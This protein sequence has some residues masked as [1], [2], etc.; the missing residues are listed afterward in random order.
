MPANYG[1]L[2]RL[3]IALIAGADETLASGIGGS[4]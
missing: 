2:A 1:G 4:H 3:S